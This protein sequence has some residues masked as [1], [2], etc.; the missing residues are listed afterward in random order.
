[1]D[2]LI[3][4]RSPVGPAAR[5][6]ALGLLFSAV[7][8]AALG[9]ALHGCGGGGGGTVPE[10]S[11]PPP[12]PTPSPSPSGPIAAQMSVPTPVGYD[13]ERLAA[14]NRLNEIRLSAGLGMVAQSTA[15]DLAAQAHADWMVAN[16]VFSHQEQAG[17]PGFLAEDWWLR[18]EAF[19]YTPVGGEEVI[20]GSSRGAAGV[21]V[22]INGV[23]HRAGMLAFEPVDVGI[24]WSSETAAHVAMPLVID[25]TRPGSDAIRGLGQAAQQ[26]I[27]GVAIWPLDHSNNVPTRLG[28]ESPNPVPDQDVLSLGTPLSITVD[29]LKTISTVSFALTEDA[30]GAVVPTRLLSNE[31]DPNFLLPPSFVG[32]V[33]LAVLSPN[34]TYIATYTGTATTFSGSFENIHRTWSFTTAA[35]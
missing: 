7:S 5:R 1:M 12:A 2:S 16:D 34:T 35:N 23:Y 10:P 27:E 22:L 33:P 25:L 11:P 30:T 3:K 15:M 18:D 8:V 13:A 32:A 21:D 14:F 29:R 19:G 4:G 28:L 26:T 17:T 9:S 20:V 6:R 31:T 24:G